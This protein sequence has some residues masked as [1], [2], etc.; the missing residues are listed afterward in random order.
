MMMERDP[1]LKKEVGGSILDC[2]IFSLLDEKL[3]RWST[4]SCA[5]ALAYRNSVSKR[6]KKTP[7]FTRRMAPHDLKLLRS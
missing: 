1:N 5:L 7:Q 3:T 4:A 6:K 2:E